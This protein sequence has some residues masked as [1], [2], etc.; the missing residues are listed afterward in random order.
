MDLL[1]EGY[2]ISNPVNMVQQGLHELNYKRLPDER[3]NAAFSIQTK[4]GPYFF[5]I[6]NRKNRG[7][8]KIEKLFQKCRQAIVSDPGQKNE[9]LLRQMRTCRMMLCHDY[10]EELQGVLCLDTLKLEL[11]HESN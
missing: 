3:R 8:E 11:L 5:N 7:K 10:C 1:C 2:A 6:M 9:V 4:I